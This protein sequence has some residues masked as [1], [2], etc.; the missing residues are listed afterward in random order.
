MKKIGKSLV[1]VAAI[2]T[3]TVVEVEL[4]LELPKIPSVPASVTVIV[5]VKLPAAL[6][7]E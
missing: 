1:A 5:T 3:L 7:S 6:G 2:C 4:S